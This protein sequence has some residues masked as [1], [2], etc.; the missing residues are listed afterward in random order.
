MT[1]LLTALT[2]VTILVAIAVAGTVKPRI[3]PTVGAVAAPPTVTISV[4]DLQ[5][6]VE[7]RT[8]PITEIEN[9]Y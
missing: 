3:F 5:R 4:E 9:L 2:A 7:M 8:L 6:Q 1:K